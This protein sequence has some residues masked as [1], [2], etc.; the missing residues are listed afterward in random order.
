MHSTDKI[1]ILIVTYNRC[2]DCLELLKN[3]SSQIDAD[4][5]I[6]EILVLNNQST[7]SYK[8]LEDYINQST[9]PFQYIHS[10]E[11]L[12]VAK[13]RNL[14]IQKAQ[15]PILLVL[16]DDV[17]LDQKD[18][19][20][21]A[22]S[23]FNKAV[24]VQNNTAIITLNIFYSETKERQKNALPH[25]HYDIYKDKEWFLTY[26]FVGAAHVMKK[27]IFEKTGLYPT[28]FFYG[29]EEYDLSFRTIEAGYTLGY[30]S[31][32]KVWHK[33]SPKGRI[34]NKQKMQM[35]WYNKSKV[36]WRYLPNIYYYTT[37][38]MWSLQYLKTTRFD[39]KGFFEQWEEIIHI[40]KNEERQALSKKAM[41][42][43]KSVKARLWY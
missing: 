9:L 18:A 39:F 24:F 13:G 32:I 8:T 26:Y 30:D 28:D 7:D 11:N 43:V 41:E 25:K 40:P 17:L 5:L 23:L 37:A 19:I 36:A 6:G 20:Q 10:S 31:S 4:I 22:A 12:G 21:K 14:L 2:D 1:S 29:M 15:F 42:Y 38:F 34:T 16:D 3:I 33:E 27:E 35:L